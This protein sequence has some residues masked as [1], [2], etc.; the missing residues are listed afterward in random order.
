MSDFTPN[1]LYAFGRVD[2][3]AGEGGEALVKV[4][5]G[6]YGLTPED[7]VIGPTTANGSAVAAESALTGTVDTQGDLTGGPAQSEGGEA[8]VLVDPATVVG[9]VDTQGGQPVSE[10]A[11]EEVPAEEAPVEGDAAE[12]VVAEEVVADGTDYASLGVTAL[13]GLLKE[14]GLPTSG[15]KDELV[16]ALQADDA[17]QAEA[18]AE[19]VN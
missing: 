14:R 16:A 6:L 13:R 17:A 3:S 12:E 4:S 2:T 7:I 18:S 8:P 10:E 11:P 1:P 9:T 19:P 5:P 15:T